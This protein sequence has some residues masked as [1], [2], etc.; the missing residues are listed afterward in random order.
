MLTRRDEE[1]LKTIHFYRYMTAIDVAY[2]LFSISSKRY[3]RGILSDLAGNQDQQPNEYLYRFGFPKAAPGNFERIFTLGNAGRDFLIK[4]AGIQVN[5]QFRPG[6]PM[7]YTLLLHSLFLTRFLVAAHHASKT[8]SF[9]VLDVKT[10]YELSGTP[11]KETVTL[12]PDAWLL[13]ERKDGRRGN[14]LLEID[15]GTEYRERFKRHVADRLEFVKSGEYEK[16][17]GEKAIIVVYVSVGDSPYKETRLKT[18]QVWTREIL[19]EQGRESWSPIFRFTS[20]SLSEVYSL[21][22]FSGAMWFQPDSVEAIP[23]FAS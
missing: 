16:L 11:G 7:S 17:F 14:I 15:R 21:P 1:I 6:R 19:K 18:M 5:W 12:I 4:H 9:K 8:G 13:I 22:L 10:S 3:V 2:R 20:M 23:I